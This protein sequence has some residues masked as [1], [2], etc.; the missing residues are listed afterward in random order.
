MPLLA[1]SFCRVP[2][3]SRAADTPT[4]FLYRFAWMRTLPPKIGRGSQATQAARCQVLDRLAG[5]GCTYRA[6]ETGEVDI[7][8]P[9]HQPGHG[10][11]PSPRIHGRFS[12]DHRSAPLVYG[13]T[14][15]HL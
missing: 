7:A 15:D 12:P 8:V 13:L 11:R 9:V 2:K 4:V 14:P 1:P 5:I 10:P 3:R 6:A